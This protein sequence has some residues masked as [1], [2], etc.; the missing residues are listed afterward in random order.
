MYCCGVDV[1]GP[2]HVLTLFQSIPPYWAPLKQQLIS[3]VGDVEADDELNRRISPLYHV[4]NIK[5]SLSTAQ[6]PWTLIDHPKG[7][8]GQPPVGPVRFLCL[9]AVQKIAG[10]KP[11]TPSSV[12]TMKIMWYAGCRC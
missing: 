7:T 5:Y 10:S 1:V 3:R 6:L 4:D 11:Q 12:I 2:S 9:L 8:M